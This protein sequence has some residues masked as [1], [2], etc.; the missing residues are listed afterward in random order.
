L[1]LHPEREHD[2]KCRVHAS[3][4]VRNGNAGTGAVS[5]RLTGYADHAALSL[6]N[7]VKRGAVAVRPVLAKAGNRAIN[8]ACI[9][10]TRA[11]VI[12]PE[13]GKR[14]DA[15]VLQHDIAALDHSQKRFLAF[16]IFQIKHHA[17]FVAMQ[18][19][20]IICFSARQWRTPGACDVS[21]T[22]RFNLD[23]LRAVIGKHGRAKRA[24]ERV[25]QVEHLDSF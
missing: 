7:E 12:E 6:D 1:L 11:V 17:L 13:S 2:A 22:G 9:S 24:G 5:T 19:G 4:Q 21:C 3:G 20:E 14:A 16:G 18:A 10:Q 15:V 23:D 8:N 25:A